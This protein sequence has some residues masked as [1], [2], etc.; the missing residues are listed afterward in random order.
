MDGAWE[1]NAN[2]G[3]SKNCMNLG[4]CRRNSSLLHIHVKNDKNDYKLVANMSYLAKENM[5]NFSVILTTF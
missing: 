5:V 4:F 3:M 1:F 2:C